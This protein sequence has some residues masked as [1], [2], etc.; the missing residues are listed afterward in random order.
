MSKPKTSPCDICGTV[1]VYPKK[2]RLCG[3]KICHKCTV[4]Y[5]IGICNDYIEPHCIKCWE[6]GTPYRDEIEQLL[7]DHNY[8]L[9]K[10]EEKWINKI[11]GM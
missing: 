11:K 5:D 6:L 10:L 7:A 8:K 9:F 1:V 4:W 3:K 2:C